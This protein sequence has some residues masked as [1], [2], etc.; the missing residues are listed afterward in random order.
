MY[1]ARRF[2]Y[3]LDILSIGQS[4][5][6]SFRDLSE[7]NHSASSFD[8]LSEAGDPAKDSRLLV[9]STALNCR[10]RTTSGARCFRR[11]FYCQRPRGMYAAPRLEQTLVP[12]GPWGALLLIRPPGRHAPHSHPQH[13][14]LA[15]PGS[16]GSLC[17]SCL[18]YTSPSPRDATLSRMPSSA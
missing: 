4:P 16:L 17:A 15:M 10:R 11:P 13:L 5:V 12:G 14:T 7:L 2:Q 1:A 9:D 3:S 8:I 6:I 18:L